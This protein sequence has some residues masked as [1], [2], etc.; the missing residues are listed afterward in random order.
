MRRMGLLGKFAAVWAC[1]GSAA[2]ESAAQNVRFRY[3]VFS[4]SSFRRG[5]ESRRRRR[6]FFLDP[7]LR[8]DDELRTL[9]IYGAVFQRRVLLQRRL[10]N[11]V[12]R[13]MRQLVDEQHVARDF[14]RRE[15]LS[16]PLRDVGGA[17]FLTG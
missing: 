10:Q 13:R 9:Q 16:A 12:R 3:T 15:M 6:L 4:S 2:S 1:A 5:P 14:L 7:G 17:R 8:R 11:L